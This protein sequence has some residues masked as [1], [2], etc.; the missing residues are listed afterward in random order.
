MEFSVENVSSGL[1]K[2]EKAC[3]GKRQ[4]GSERRKVISG[5]WEWQDHLATKEHKRQ[6]YADLSFVLF[7]LL[8]GL[9]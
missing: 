8:C 1:W 3:G 4:A 6:K 9:I 2:I 7:V 5:A